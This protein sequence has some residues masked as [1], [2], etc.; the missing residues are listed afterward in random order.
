MGIVTTGFTEVDEGWAVVPI[1]AFDRFAPF[2]R[3]EQEVRLEP[4]LSSVEVEV[5]P[6]GREQRLRHAVHIATREH[7]RGRFCN[8]ST[9]PQYQT[10]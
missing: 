10:D 4:V 9:H 6:V 1:G 3:T 2:A 5:P 8:G 7:E